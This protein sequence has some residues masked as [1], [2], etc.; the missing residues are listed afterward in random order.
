MHIRAF[1]LG[2]LVAMVKKEVDYDAEAAQTYA[3]NLKFIN[4]LDM[5]SA[6]MEGT[7]SDDYME[8]R[9]KPVVWT[10][11][12]KFVDGGKKEAEA[13]D[14]LAEVAGNG[15][16]ALA[17]AVKDLAQLG[18]TPHD[19]RRWEQLV[20]RPNGIILV[21][22]PTGSGKTTTLYSTL[23][24]VA[25]EEVNVSTIEDPIEN[26]DPRLNQTQVQPQLGLS[27]AEGVRSLMRQDPDIIMIGEIRDLETA[28]IA[29]KAA[30]TGHLV[31]STLHTNDAAS[32]ITRLIDM[33]VEPFLLSSSLLGALAQRLVRK[34]CTTCHGQGCDLCSQTGYQGRTGVFELLVVD[35]EIRAQIHG[36]APEAHIRHRQR[37][38]V[39]ARRNLQPEVI[40]VARQPE[41]HLSPA[42]RVQPLPQPP[43]RRAIHLHERYGIA[44]RRPAGRKIRRHRPAVV[45]QQIQ[46]A[47]HR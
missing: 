40:V 31:L 17:P 20:A 11:G 34:L 3:N 32:A 15:L 7:S 6:W 21:T 38:R 2:Q 37:R 35:D 9:A 24:R 41:R 1:N 8:S 18:F 28:E 22:G 33:G 25:T 14:K 46:R 30:Q 43:D 45:V 39:R 12:D 5:R 27:F 23:R 47:Q 42:P 19:A 44:P 29:I 36:Q 10:E 26:I 13:A 4:Q 16:N